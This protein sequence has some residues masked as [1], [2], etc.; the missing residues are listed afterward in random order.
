MPEA[1]SI[2]E[3]VNACDECAFDCAI[4]DYR[5]P[6]DDGLRGID[7]LREPAAVMAVIMAT[8]VGDEMVATEA[9]KRGAATTSLK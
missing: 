4:I 8:G 3:A 2:E 9:M 5:M 1:V 7:A 6:G